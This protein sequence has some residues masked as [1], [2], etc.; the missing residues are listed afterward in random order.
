MS[1]GPCFTRLIACQ[2]ERSGDSTRTIVDVRS[3]G[4][5]RCPSIMFGAFFFLRAGV[6]FLRS[7]ARDVFPKSTVRFAGKSRALF[8]MLALRS[9]VSAG[10]SRLSLRSRRARFR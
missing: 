3:P 4:K 7:G 6:T 10:T 9:A 2:A 5:F 1:C 8:R